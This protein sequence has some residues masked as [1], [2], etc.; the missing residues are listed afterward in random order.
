MAGGLE[1]YRGVSVGGL[2]LSSLLV[3]VEGCEVSGIG[4]GATALPAATSSSPFGSSSCA[5][6]RVTALILP[7]ASSTNT[8]SVGGASP[9][10]VR[11]PK[12]P[13]P[14]LRDKL[15]QSSHMTTPGAAIHG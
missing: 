8:H 14:D 10:V 6:S 13:I 11:L 9:G 7:P 1:I 5:T 15:I 2:V 12:S 3:I 4:R